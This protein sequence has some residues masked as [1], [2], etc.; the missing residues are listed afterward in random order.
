MKLVDLLERE[1]G[2]IVVALTLMFIGAGLWRMGVPKSEDIIPF[3]LG[4]LGR[5][6]GSIA[7]GIT[8]G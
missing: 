5:S 1:S 8:K 2:H 4:L 7:N 6:M 3:A